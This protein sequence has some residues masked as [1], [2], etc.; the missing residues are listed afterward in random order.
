MC[1][2]AHNVFQAKDINVLSVG[3][4]AK[5][6]SLSDRYSPQSRVDCPLKPLEKGH[7]REEDRAISLLQPG[8]CWGKLGRE[9]KTGN[10]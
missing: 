9:K 4:V 2:E 10:V 8:E 3:K 5:T 7:R 1:H 6:H